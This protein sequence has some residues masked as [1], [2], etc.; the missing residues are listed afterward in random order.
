MSNSLPRRSVKA[1]CRSSWRLKSLHG[2]GISK[3]CRRQWSSWVQSKGLFRVFMLRCFTDWKSSETMKAKLT[4]RTKLAMCFL[5]WTNVSLLWCIHR[6][7]EMG[8]LFTVV[9]S[10]NTLES[11]LLQVRSRDTTI[12]ETMHISEIKNFLSRYI[13]AA[14]NI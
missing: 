2:L 4:I 1:F 11:G 14:D 12:K 7:D 10:E 8:V 13:S 6:Y 9:I 3:L 5:L